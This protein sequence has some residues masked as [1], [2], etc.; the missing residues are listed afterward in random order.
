MSRLR[1]IAGNPLA[2]LLLNYY[3]DDWGRLWYIL[4]EGRAGILQVGKEHAAALRRLRSKYRPYR[5]MQLAYRGMQLAYR[6]MQLEDTPV[7]KILP[8]RPIRW[9]AR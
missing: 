7:I 6:G 4:A 8:R 3:E 1:H 2:D 5:G 9:H